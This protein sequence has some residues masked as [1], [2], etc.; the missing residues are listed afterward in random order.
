MSAETPTRIDWFK[1]VV[2]VLLTLIGVFVACI[3]F[4]E[5]YASLRAAD[6]SQQSAFKAVNATGLYFQ[7]N[8]QAAQG[9]DIAQRYQELL[10]RAVRADTKARALRLGGQ[11]ELATDS[12]SDAERWQTA[13]AGLV[14]RDPLMVEYEQDVDLYREALLRGAYE[15]EEREHTLLEQSRAWDNKSN[16]YVA[17]LSTLS[18]ALFLL[19]LSLTI[20]S[21]MRYVLAVVGIGLTG[22]CFLWMLWVIIYPVPIISEDA[23]QRFVDG[24]VK[25]NL[26]QA[27]LEQDYSAAMEDF[28]AAIELAPDYGRAYFYRSLANTDASLLAKHLDTQQAID[29]GL[30][31]LEL[32]SPTAPTLG[33]LGRLYYLNGQYKSAL[34]YTEQALALAPDDCYLSFNQGLILMALERPTD[35]QAAYDAAI[36]CAQNQASDANLTNYLDTGVTDLKELAIARE[37]LAESLNPAIQRLKEALASLRMFGTIERHE[38]DADFGDIAFGTTVNNDDIVQNIDTEFPQT[39]TII[40][41]QLPY[42][43]MSEDHRWYTRWKLDGREYLS[44]FYAEW[45]YSENG[46]TWINLRNIGG[47]NPGTYE[48]D[49]FVEGVL[50]TSG[51]VVVLPGDLP[52]M[53]YYHSNSV[54]VTLAYPKDWKITSLSDN[55]V[56]VIAARDPNRPT[57]FGVTAWVADTGT[58]EDVFELFDLHEEALDAEFA[59]V[60]FEEREEFTVAGLDGWFAYYEYEDRE[61]QLIQGALVGALNEDKTLSYMVAVESLDEDWDGLVD[62]FNVMLKRM[63]VDE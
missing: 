8:L 34:D 45:V 12:D 22:F 10:Q 32:G 58:D 21:R 13:A 35:A 41:A 55:E 20:A 23:I 17:I 16:G 49:V 18:V 28:D 62:V 38:T 11:G 47:L 19:G 53:D 52:A 48:L 2:I 39:T 46:E 15:D 44:T 43:N 42:E 37:D 33:N 61:G 60:S 29:D 63:V 3:T 51:E 9:A 57:F 5:N 25:Y 59:D 36:H 14:T 54:G 26:S 7:A 4:L 56:S 24:R 1:N 6:L 31:A 30:K 40:Y 27:R 50:V